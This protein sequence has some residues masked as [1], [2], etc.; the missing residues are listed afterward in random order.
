[1]IFSAQGKFRASGYDSIIHTTASQKKDVMHNAPVTLAIYWTCWML[2][3][4]NKYQ[5]VYCGYSPMRV[6]W[7]LFCNV[8]PSVWTM[9]KFHLLTRS[10][11]SFI[12]VSKIIFCRYHSGIL[13]FCAEYTNYRIDFKTE[14]MYSLLVTTR[15]LNTSNFTYNGEFSN[16]IYLF[17]LDFEST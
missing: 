2:N 3:A 7:S 12:N 15:G 10:S 8:F 5:F 11:S 9:R 4:L 1:M 14:C 6:T 13:T 17:R 16:P